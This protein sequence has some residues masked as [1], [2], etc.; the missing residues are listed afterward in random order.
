MSTLFT[1]SLD[2]K[3]QE[4]YQKLANFADDF[5]LAG[6]TAIML[7]LNH[8]QSFD[9]DCFSEKPI[10]Q[11]FIRKAAKVF[12]DNIVV[13]VNNPD[14][15]LFLTP[16]NV[17]IDF[18]YYPYPPNHKL[19]AEGPLPIFSLADL[20]ADKARTIGRRATW[21][22]YVDLFF[23]LKRD[24]LTLD[25]IISESK[26]RFKGEFGDKLFLE[27]LSYFADLEIVPIGYL[28]ESYTP[29]EI[30]DFLNS[31]VLAQTIK[32]LNK[33][34]QIKDQSRATVKP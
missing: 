12:G 25:K 32:G 5:V 10:K 1:D 29:E 30:Q 9:F 20:A 31:A 14:L 8:R 3:R 23:F 27:Q 6:G 28:Q 24:I 21:R 7:Q 22:D 11:S 2:P 13:Q 15:L 4:V 16:E 17:K 26:K 19:V 33:P 34:G 18:V